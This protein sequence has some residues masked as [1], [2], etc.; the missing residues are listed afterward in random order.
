MHAPGQLG[1]GLRRDVNL[2]CILQSL[3]RGDGT[4]PGVAHL[5]H[6]LHHIGAELRLGQGGLAARD[7]E[8]P[9]QCDQIEQPERQQAPQLQLVGETYAFKRE[10]R[11]GNSAGLIGRCQSRPTLSQQGLHCRA[12]GQCQLH[13]VTL[14]QGIAQ[15]LAGQLTARLRLLLRAA[16]L[17]LA[18]R[19]IAACAVGVLQRLVKIN[20]STAGQ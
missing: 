5:R 3:L 9:W 6:L 7:I 14:G 10:H 12:V 16:Q 8:A 18:L 15:Q 19:E 4:H 13:R 2:L 11:V 20:P 1:T 17:K